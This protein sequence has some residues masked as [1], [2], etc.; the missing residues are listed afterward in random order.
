MKFKRISILISLVAISGC[1]YL[2][3]FRQ[4]SP[5]APCCASTG[6]DSTIQAAIAA[7]GLNQPWGMAFL[8]DDSILYT[9]RPGKIKRIVDGQVSNALD[10]LPAITAKGQGGLLDIAIDPEFADNQRIYFSYTEP[11]ENGNEFGTAVGRGRIDL[12]AMVLTEFE[13]IFTIAKKTS[14][15]Q[16][17]GS[18]LRFANDQTLFITLGDRGSQPRAQDPFDHAGSV[19]RIHLDGSVPA[20]NPFAD[21]QQG[22]PEIWSIGHRSPQGAAI[23]FDTGE[24]WT[25]SHGPR[26]GDE[27]NRVLAGRNYG[28]PDISYGINY[29]GRGFAKGHEAEG[30]EQP[31]YYWDPS[32]APSGLTFYNPETPL[33]PS[34]KGSLL[35]GALKAG[36][37]SRLILEGNS[38][39]AEEKYLE[40]QF[41]RIRDVRTGPDGAVWLL[42]DGANGKLIRVTA[43]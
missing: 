2:G 1:V 36:Y 32:I 30:M 11:N 39:V 6:D 27:I 43:Q 24:L 41:G 16:H 31:L 17:F 19:I 3:V 15:G 9:E 13:R 12:N 23:H 35:A 33:I 38:I 26:G 8:P 14:S 21:G 42:T 37:L 10:G 5:A 4:V 25:L 18:R 7:E 29:S 28:W 34:W 40:G 22:L 20:D